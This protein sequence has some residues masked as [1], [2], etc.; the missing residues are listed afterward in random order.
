[1]NRLNCNP[2]IWR[3]ILKT[4]TNHYLK[5]SK[6]ILFLCS[7]YMFTLQ[8][9]YKISFEKGWLSRLR[10]MH[11]M[12]DFRKKGEFKHWIAITNLFICATIFKKIN[13]NLSC[14]CGKLYSILQKN[15]LMTWKKKILFFFNNNIRQQQFS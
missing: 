3:I 7:A 2:C 6:T 15:F 5:T 1:M 9:K 14:H 12:L 4:T 13:Q 10:K 8:F 11:P